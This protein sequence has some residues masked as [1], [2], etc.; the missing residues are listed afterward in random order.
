M[1]W[2][3]EAIALRHLAEAI[4]HVE[5]LKLFTYQVQFQDDVRV[6]WGTGASCSGY[7]EM[8]LAISRIVSEGFDALRTEAIT[9]AEAF[10][11]TR[12]KELAECY[13]PS[14]GPKP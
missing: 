5:M 11:E 2:S 3:A 8:S 9:R 4:D 6:T 7:K 13:E 12:R 10:I 1:T 14:A